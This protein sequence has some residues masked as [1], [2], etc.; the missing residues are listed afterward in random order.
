MSLTK[1]LIPFLLLAAGLAAVWQFGL[2]DR[3][4]WTAL[5]QYQET[6]QRLVA[7][8]PLLAAAAYV[9]FY[10]AAVALSV[11]EGA[12]MTVFGGLLFG[13]ITGGVLAVIGATCGAIILFLVVRNLL[14]DVVA[15][16][17]SR[18]IGRIRPGL[19]RDGFNYLLAIRLVP[20]VP[21]WLVNLAPALV[22]MR[23]VPFAL[24][25]L[26]GIVPSTFVFA[27]IGAGFAEVLAAGGRPELSSLLSLR[28]VL[29]LVALAFLVLL[30]VIL[31]RAKALGA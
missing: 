29:P 22:G 4:S 17:A 21:F 9:F 23:L 13:T 2:A 26:I 16:R 10:A 8:W 27:W 25:T 30:P 3:L 18:L 14:A 7:E 19:E 28:F 24:A 15:C 1:R 5:S 6:L 11:P 12:A 31:R 20:V